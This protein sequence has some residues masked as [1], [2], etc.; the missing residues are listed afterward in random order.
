MA[1]A[2]LQVKEGYQPNKLLLCCNQQDSPSIFFY[3]NLLNTRKQKKYYQQATY[4]DEISMLPQ[5]S[6]ALFFQEIDL[7]NAIVT[8]R[9]TYDE[10]LEICPQQT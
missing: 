6:A 4:E 9:S 3:H 7:L 2:L 10:P 8:T 1:T 5:P